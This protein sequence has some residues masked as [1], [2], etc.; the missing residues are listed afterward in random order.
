M[1]PC[2]GAEGWLGRGTLINRGISLLPSLS[3]L[4]AM[5]TALNVFILA[6]LLGIGSPQTAVSFKPAATTR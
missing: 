3:L 4:V 5:G 6:P 2:T 1:A